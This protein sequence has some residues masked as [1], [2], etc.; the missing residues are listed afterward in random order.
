MNHNGFLLGKKGYQ[1]SILYSG[2]FHIWTKK[3]YVVE[4]LG[5]AQL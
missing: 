3:Y 4:Q 2:K 5:D 1:K